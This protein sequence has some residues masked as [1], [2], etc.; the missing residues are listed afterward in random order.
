[1]KFPMHVAENIEYVVIQTSFCFTSVSLDVIYFVVC[2]V[3]MQ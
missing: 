3:R 2:E 1:M